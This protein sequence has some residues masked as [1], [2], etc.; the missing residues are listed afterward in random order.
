MDD[1]SPVENMQLNHVCVA[2]LSAEYQRQLKFK[3][4]TRIQKGPPWNTYDEWSRAHALAFIQ[5]EI[6]LAQGEAA[7][8]RE[9]VTNVLRTQN[10]AGGLSVPP[11]L[12]IY[13]LRRLGSFFVG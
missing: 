3:L 1:L 10:G 11:P 5:A 9:R 7:C 2:R 12:Q 4:D 8:R 6:S 13:D